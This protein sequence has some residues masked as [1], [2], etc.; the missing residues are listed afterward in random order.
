MGTKAALLVGIN[1][2]SV[3]EAT[4]GGCI[5]D[6]VGMKTMLVQHMGYRDQDVVV[7][8]DDDP[9]AMPT[10]A[11]MTAALRQLMASSSK[12]SEIWFHYSGHGAQIQDPKSPTI[13]DSILVPVDYETSGFI[14]DNELFAIFQ[15]AKCP[16][17]AVVDCCHSGNVCELPY[18]TEYVSPGKFRTVKTNRPTMVNPNVVVFS[19]CKENQTAGDFFDQ[20]DQQREGVFSDTFL[21]SLAALNYTCSLQD[22]FQRICITLTAGGFTQTPVVS[23]SSTPLTWKFGINQMPGIAQQLGLTQQIDVLFQQ[24][25]QKQTTAPPPPPPLVAIHL[26]TEPVVPPLPIRIAPS[27]TRRPNV[28]ARFSMFP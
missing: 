13:Y 27:R 2:T 16:T 4:L 23:S 12:C 24:Q 9:Q 18:V 1:Y 8:R 6:V 17:F 26:L 5:D 28:Q 20:D 21:D 25:K 10:R 14:T 19:G 22:L 11:N 15:Y 7:L 3:P